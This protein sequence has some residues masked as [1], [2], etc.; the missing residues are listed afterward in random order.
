VAAAL[1]EAFAEGR[2]LLAGAA[3]AGDPVAV[4]PVAYH[5][6]WLREL[7]CDLSVLLSGASMAWR[8]PAG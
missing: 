1:L 4:L 3:Q 7:S 5:L 6:L 8:E 2:P